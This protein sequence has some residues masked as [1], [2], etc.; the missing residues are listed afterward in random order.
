MPVK[1]S[2]R[3]EEYY[4]RKEFEDKQKREEVK[5]IE[6]ELAEKQKLKDLHFMNCPKCGM[7]LIEVNYKNI[8]VDKCSGCNGI[9]LDAGELEAVAKLNQG[10][11][12]NWFDTFKK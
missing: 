2:D 5:Q 1:P 7:K 6:M 8:E 10:V 11:L 4:A 3:E 12:N 9:W